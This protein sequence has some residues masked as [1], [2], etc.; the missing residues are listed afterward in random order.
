MISELEPDVQRDEA[1][2]AKAPALDA[3]GLLQALQQVSPTFRDCKPLAIRIDKAVGERFPE[4]ERKVVRNAMRIHTAST[5]YLKAME[6]GGARFDLDGKEDGTVT[7]EQREHARQTLKE[8]F[9]EAAKRRKAAEQAE[10][11]KRE[12]EEAER[13]KSQKLQQLVGKFSKR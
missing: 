8:R 7:D 1:A 3:R 4:V 13:R 10:K 11:A 9:A 2:P 6:K 12:A 5:R